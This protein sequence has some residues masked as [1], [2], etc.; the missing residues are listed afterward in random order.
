MPNSCQRCESISSWNNEDPRHVVFQKLLDA[1]WRRKFC[2]SN[3]SFVDKI[4]DLHV[5]WSSS[6][7]WKTSNSH[8]Q[9][10]RKIPVF[11]Y[12]FFGD[13]AHLLWIQKQM[14]QEQRGARFF[15][16]W[17]CQS[18]LSCLS[19]KLEVW[20]R[21]VIYRSLHLTANKTTLLKTVFWVFL[22]AFQFL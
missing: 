14:D 17:V 18:K 9:L 1:F 2:Q 21:F 13:T 3:R 4:T 8:I 11:V 16:T 6:S 12:G 22:L 5:V 20:I 10:R 7:K 19:T 15:Y